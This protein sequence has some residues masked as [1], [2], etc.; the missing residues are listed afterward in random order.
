MTTDKNTSKMQISK[1]FN[2][3]KMPIA[4]DRV[5]AVSSRFSVN[6]SKTILIFLYPL[7]S[8]FEALECAAI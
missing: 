5:L 3:D 7:L 8:T 2:L 6:C 4:S 1:V